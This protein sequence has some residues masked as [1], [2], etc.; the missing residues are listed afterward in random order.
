MGKRE[1]TLYM[2]DR[3]GAEMKEA[4]LV[5]TFHFIHI[6]KWYVPYPNTSHY[7]VKYICKNCFK[8]FKKWY[9][10]EGDGE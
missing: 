6:F 2:C 8:S 5:G 9:D 4:Y 1:I 3:C 7:T 10:E